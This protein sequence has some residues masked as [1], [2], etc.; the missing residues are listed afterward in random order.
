MTRGGKRRG[1]GR[2]TGA[3]VERKPVPVRLPVDVHQ[4]MMDTKHDDESVNQFVTKAV[5]AEAA[6][7]SP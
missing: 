6:R 2:P 1:A 3:G 7:R 5:A 4:A